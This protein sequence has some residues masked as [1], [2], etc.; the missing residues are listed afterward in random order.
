MAR[1]KISNRPF[2]ERAKPLPCP[3]CGKR[4]VSPYVQGSDGHAYRDC[5]YCG[6]H[7]TFDFASKQWSYWRMPGERP[8][9]PVNPLAMILAVSQ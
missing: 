8:D 1:S 7:Q 9:Y 6:A 3:K 2:Q 4:G 5:R